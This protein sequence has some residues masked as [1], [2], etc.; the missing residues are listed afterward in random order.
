MKKFLLYS[1]ALGLCAAIGWLMIAGMRMRRPVRPVYPVSRHI[2]Y[3]FTLP[4]RT[5]RVVKGVVF[6]TRGPV[7]QTAAQ[8]CVHLES[9]HPYRL[10]ADGLG[11][12]ILS[13]DLDDFPPYATR[14]IQITADLRLSAVP[15]RLSGKEED[16]AAFLRPQPYCESDHPD[17]RALAKR[18]KGPGPAQTAENIFRWVSDNVQYSGYLK[19]ARGAL[20][21]L[22]EKKGDCTEF[23]YLFAALCRASHIPARCIGGYVCPK[24]MILKPAGYHNWAECRLDNRWWIADPLTGTFRKTPAR[25]IAM[26][27]IPP[28]LDDPASRF[29][30]FSVK[31][32]GIEAT[33]N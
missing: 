5:N 2:Q 30:R 8:L 10:L 21:A 12:R 13:F 28:V 4:N 16:I 25:Y 7:K 24:N 18:L 31:G 9:S 26:R 15:N 27:I 20:Y 3:A 32:E 22:R 17:I 33:M 11:N 1:A 6:R 19:H 23:M 29:N 14:V